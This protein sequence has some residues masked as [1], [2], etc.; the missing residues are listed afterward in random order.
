MAEPTA[1]MRGDKVR[2]NWRILRKVI[3]SL[4]ADADHRGF[5][6]TPALLNHLLSLH[7]F[8]GDKLKNQG[9]R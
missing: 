7:Y 9:D 8:G 2:V 6:S 3:K 1:K 5:S 4:E